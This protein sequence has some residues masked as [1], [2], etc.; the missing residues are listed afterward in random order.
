MSIALILSPSHQRRLVCIAKEAGCKPQALM[1]DVFRY[2]I[3]W[4]EADVRETRAGIAEGEAGLGVP[5]AEV[6]RR[7]H[8]IIAT[9][10]ANKEKQAA[11][12]SSPFHAV[13]L[14]PSLES[15]VYQ[16]FQGGLGLK[17]EDVLDKGRKDA[18]RCARL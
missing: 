17:C 15:V 13:L 11:L 3:D 10:R 16:G 14:A 4:V 6:R 18:R 12:R 2:G 1:D 5:D 8:K 9:V 7:A